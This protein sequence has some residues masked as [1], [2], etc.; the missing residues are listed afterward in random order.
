MRIVAEETCIGGAVFIGIGLAEEVGIRGGVAV[1]GEDIVG[2]H[3]CLRFIS[4]AD[5]FYN[6]QKY[7]IILLSN[8][9]WG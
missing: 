5:W 2:G 9:S 4:L 1:I 7:K 8:L 3:L 6:S